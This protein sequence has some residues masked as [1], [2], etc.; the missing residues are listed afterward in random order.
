[1]PTV[2]DSS[3]SILLAYMSRLPLLPTNVTEV[4]STPRKD[5][6]GVIHNHFP[7]FHYYDATNEKQQ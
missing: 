7:Y 5:K 6:I 4:A 1:L 3:G 2:T